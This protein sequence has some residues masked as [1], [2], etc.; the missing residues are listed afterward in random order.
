MPPL[1]S[2]AFTR[3]P[4]TPVPQCRAAPSPA[5][6]GRHGPRAEEA[7][8]RALRPARAANCL[9][10][11]SIA[12]RG[13]SAAGGA[14]ERRVLRRGVG[15]AGRSLLPGEA[16]AIGPTSASLP[17]GSGGGGELLRPALGRGAVNGHP[18]G[19]GRGGARDLSVPL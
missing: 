1:L 10:D 14:G 12:A 13:G 18:E 2:A 5:L 6:Y 7:A 17:R 16:P 19:A 4:A 8:R 9:P 15:G 3:R 11:S